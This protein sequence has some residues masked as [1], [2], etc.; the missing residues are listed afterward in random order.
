MLSSFAIE[1]Q[2][3]RFQF[4]LLSTTAILCVEVFNC[5]SQLIIDNIKHTEFANTN[6]QRFYFS[7]YHPLTCYCWQLTVKRRIQLKSK[8]LEK[9]FQN[10]HS[11]V[12][13]IFDEKSVQAKKKSVSVRF[14]KIRYFNPN[15]GIFHLLCRNFV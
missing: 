1:L 10:Q 11:E 14:K 6:T 5:F 2:L 4:T 3:C 9:I 7:V 12:K 13:P 15:L 8:T